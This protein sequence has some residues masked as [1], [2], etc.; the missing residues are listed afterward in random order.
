MEYVKETFGVAYSVRGL[1]K[2]L[3]QHGFAYH[4]PVGVP[5]KADGLAQKA[6][7]MW[8]EKFK[9][10]LPDDRRSSLTIGQRALK[11]VRCLWLKI[12]RKKAGAWKSRPMAARG[13]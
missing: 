9:K 1:T 11:R 13:V 10:S 7:I 3:K 5:K 12:I 8:Y 2:W 6:W 4:K